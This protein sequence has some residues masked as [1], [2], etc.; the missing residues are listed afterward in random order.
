LLSDYIGEIAAL[1]A[2]AAWVF[3][4][5]FFTLG[6]KRVGAMVVNRTRLVFAV[7][8]VGATHWALFGQPFPTGEEPSRYLWLS[9][10]AVIGLVI[11]DSLLFQSYVLV[12][13]RLGV[14]MFVFGPVFTAL[15]GWLFL[16]EGMALIEVAGMGL[17][18]AGVF[19]VILERQSGPVGIAQRDPRN[20]RL[21]ILFGIGAQ[22]SNAA[23]LVTSKRGLVGDFP[24]LSA[25]MVRMTV[26]LVVIWLLALVMGEVGRTIRRLNADHRGTAIILG[27]AFAGPFVGVWLS[28]TAVQSSRVG[29][30]GTL[31][32]LTPILSLPVVR[33]V[34]KERVSPRTI[35]GTLV[36][37]AGVA[38]MVLY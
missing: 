32:S 35:L 1:G 7:L 11:G 27:G 6:G 36:A 25:A 12:G 8:L 33:F 17:V 29:I 28:M 38:L 9:L 34:L 24:P 20:F 15:G 13:A 26:G 16:G 14:L 30:A 23:Q 2:A 3:S 4:S 10:S 18:L 5:L 21:G 37:M 19:W 31:M 22:L